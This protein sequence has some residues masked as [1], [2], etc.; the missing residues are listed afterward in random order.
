MEAGN[1][2]VYVIIHWC[3]RANVANSENLS[4]SWVFTG[5]EDLPHTYSGQI[6]LICDLS[7]SGGERKT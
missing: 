1:S 5:P 7:Q 2:A 3:V 4:D 6:R